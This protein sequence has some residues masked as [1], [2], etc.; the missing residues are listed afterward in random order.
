MEMIAS[1]GSGFF[2]SCLSQR[3]WKVE[4]LDWIGKVLSEIPSPSWGEGSICYLSNEPWERKS[5]RISIVVGWMASLYLAN[6]FT[7]H[8]TLG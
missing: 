5:L 4:D 7:Y 6:Y 3:T 1:L 8:H 2:M